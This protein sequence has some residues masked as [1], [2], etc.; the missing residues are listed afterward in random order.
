[1]DEK[2]KAAVDDGKNRKDKTE[3]YEKLL[4]QTLGTVDCRCDM[5]CELLKDIAKALEE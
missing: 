2:T 5:C 3:L 4:R 1:M